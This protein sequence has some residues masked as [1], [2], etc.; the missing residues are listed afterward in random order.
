MRVKK[1]NPSRHTCCCPNPEHDDENPSCS[2]NPKTYSYKCFG[3]GYTVDIVD[4][5]MQSS[6]CTFIEACEKLFDLAQVSYDF[7]EKGVLTDREYRYPKPKYAKNK[8]KVYE[9]WGS[10]HISPET[11]D[12]L[13]IMQDEEGNTLFQYYDLNDVLTMVKVRPSRKVEKGSGPKIWC[14]PGADTQPL[15]YNCQKINP[16]QPLIICSGEGDCATAVECGF[17]N[18]VSIP[19]GDGNSKWISELWEW[20]QQFSSIILVHD[21]DK[22]GEGFAKDTTN[23]LG[24]W[25]VKNAVI[26]KTTPPDEDGKVY[27]INDLNELLHYCGKEAVIKSLSEARD[28]DVPTL[29]DFSD[30]A[31]E[32]MSDVDG[33]VSGFPDLDAAIDKFYEGS[34]NILTGVAGSGKSSFLSTLISRALD[35]NFPTFIYSGEL[36]NASLKGWISSVMAGQ[37]N[38]NRYEGVTSPYYKIVPA[39]QAE[40]N[41]FYKGKLFFLRDTV[42]QKVSTILQKM[43]SDVRKYGVRLLIIDNITSLDLEN[44]DDNKYQKQDELIREVISFTKKWNVITFI[45]V[46]PKKIQEVK[47]L[48]LFD[49]GGVVSTV[50]LAHRVFSLYR[51]QPKDKAGTYGPAN[52]YDVE[53]SIL[54]DRFGSAMNKKFGLY[55]DIPSKRFFETKETLDHRYLWDKKDYG[56]TPLPYGAPQLDNE[57]EIYGEEI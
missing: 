3:C 46:H 52:P 14:L 43:E 10:R 53:I 41:K 4:A 48:D 36:S 26:P 37:R 23:R 19:L 32:D 55:Y 54:K 47:R 6:G 33:F 18:T 1:Y 31:R 50:N 5:Y 22:S 28:A 56:T 27:R 51:V 15:L 44:N 57:K 8:D 38:I 16:A 7:T 2:Y 30:V 24:E 13:G 21:N 45:V 9:Y 49:L 34:V 11:I 25:R 35:Q 20:L 40:I 17:K 42:E 39:A 12:Y 29:V